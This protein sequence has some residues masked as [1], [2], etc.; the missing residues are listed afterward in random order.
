MGNKEGEKK[1]IKIPKNGKQIKK[2][3]RNFINIERNSNAI[4]KWKSA[5]IKVKLLFLLSKLTNDIQLYGSPVYADSEFHFMNLV[6]L[7]N[8]PATQITNEPEVPFF[9]LHPNSRFKM[10]WSLFMILPFVYVS[11]IIPLEVAFSSVNG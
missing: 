9:I 1:L 11:F 3:R 10:L 7:S 8:T 5:L 4:K 2:V 6:K